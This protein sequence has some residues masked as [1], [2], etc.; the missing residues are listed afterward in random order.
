M[1]DNIYIVGTTAI[2]RP[3]LHNIVIPKWKKWLLGCGGKLKWFINIDILEHLQESYESTKQNFEKLFD[4]SRIEPIILQ[5]QHNKFLGACKNL[6]ENIRNYVEIM[7][8]DKNNLKIIWLEDDWEL[9]EDPP[10]F[11]QLEKYC[12]GM[13]HLNLSGIKNNYIWALAP[14]IITYELWLNIFYEAW[15]NQQFDICPEKSVGK[16]Y[17]T[18]YCNHEDT[19]NIILLSEK[20]DQ[21]LIKD[22]IFKNTKIFYLYR[23]NSNELALEDAKSLNPHSNELALEDAKSLNPHSNELEL[24]DA[25]FLSLVPQLNEL[26]LEDA[27]S[28]NPHSNELELE[29]AKFLSLVPQLNTIAWGGQGGTAVPPPVFIKLF[30]K[31]A[32]DIGIEY[33][34]NKNITK[35]YVKKNRNQV[36]IE[37]IKL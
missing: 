28:L 22:M 15:K 11:C 2:N 36:I 1:G 10:T 4:D 31:I 7:G 29:D 18:K 5:Q 37:Y 33:M 3:D 14:S 21:E 17:K 35:K 30:P 24:K 34:K 20:T 16:Y 23:N 26:A 6:S 12:Q 25:K 32:F 9:I 13:S 8:L 19:H 27:K